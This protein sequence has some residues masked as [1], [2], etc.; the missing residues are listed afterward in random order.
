MSP[1][2]HRGAGR[3]K[4]G[5]HLRLLLLILG[6]GGIFA[7]ET[8][9][10]QSRESLAGESA[11]EALKKS[12]EAESYNQLYGPVRVRTSASLGINYTDNVFYSNQ[13]KED[14]MIRPEVTLAALWPITELNT[15]NLSLGLSYEWYLNNR[16]LNADAPLVNPGS[17]LAFNIFVGDFRIQLHERFSYQESLFINTATGDNSQFFNFNNVGTFKRLDDMTGFL[18]TWDLNKVLLSAGYDHE[19]FSSSTGSFEYLNRASEWLTASAGYFL[20]DHVQ[21]GLE[22]RASF[23]DYN[24]EAVLNDNWRARIGPF[25]EAEFPQKITLRAGAGYD[26]A[27][28]DVDAPP[29]ILLGG[30]NAPGDYDSYYAY[31]RIRQE[32]RLFSHSLEAGHETVLGDNANN[33]RTTY[34]RYSISS[35]I[36]AHVSLGA[37]VSVNVGEEFGGAFE[38]HFTYYDAGFQVEYQLAKY[39]RTDLSY[40]FRLKQSDLPQRDYHRNQVTLDVVWSF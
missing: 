14:M 19:I 11:A 31:A 36:V 27:R 10:A 18:V 30:T 20:G 17:E 15:L 8:G 35:P 37:N 16:V 21:T 38:E 4:P 22:G 3:A 25:V 28:Y 6:C 32:T 29:G 5:G 40:G 13:P 9:H 24:Q 39:W 23:H 26:A 33:M 12:I 1:I 34:A 7:W 2:L